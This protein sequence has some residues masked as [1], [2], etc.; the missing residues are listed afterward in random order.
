[1]S[2][3]KVQIVPR[4]STVV[5]HLHG[6]ASVEATDRF[7]SALQPAIAGKPSRVVLDLTLLEFINSM[8][9]GV[10]LEFRKQLAQFKTELRLAGASQKITEVFKRTRLAELFPMFPTADKAAMD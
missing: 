2:E 8:G 3:F 5:V 6:D 4:G 9:L 10:L 7:R 1:M